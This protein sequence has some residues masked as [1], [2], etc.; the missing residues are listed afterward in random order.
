MADRRR[1]W[2]ATI[3]AAAGLFSCDGLRSHLEARALPDLLDDWA[4]GGPPTGV[5][6]PDAGGDGGAGSEAGADGG[7]GGKGASEAMPALRWTRVAAPSAQGFYGVGGLG[8]DGGL[9]LFVAADSKLLRRREG[10]WEVAYESSTHAP[11]KSLVVS[12]TGLVASVG[13]DRV[14]TCTDNCAQTA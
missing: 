12:S 10:N 11:Q 2:V 13:E 14:S 5:P 9:T 6:A 8:G 3:V 4:D 7:D 1:A